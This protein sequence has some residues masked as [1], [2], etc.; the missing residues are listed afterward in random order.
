MTM[1]LIV[2]LFF[3]AIFLG[4]LFL[5]NLYATVK[6][7]PAYEL[8][9]RLRNLAVQGDERISSDLAKEIMLEMSNLTSF[10]TDI[11]HC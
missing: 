6:K 11:P 5:Y 7:S 2:F 8:K 4:L 9:K 1:Q 10:F 3:T